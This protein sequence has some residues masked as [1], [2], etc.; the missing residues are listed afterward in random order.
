MIIMICTDNR[1]G[2]MFNK[3][4]QS[5]DRILYSRISRII[6]GEKLYLRPYSAELFNEYN[7]NLFIDDS[8]LDSAGKGDFCFVEGDA[9]AKYEPL[10]EKIILFKWNRD[11]PYDKKLD[12]D[13]SKGWIMNYTEDFSGSSHEKITMEIYERDE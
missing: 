11:Y 12:I 7:L 9:L 1:M 2:T 3:R 8:F 6:K 4:R 10:F 13:L 5:R